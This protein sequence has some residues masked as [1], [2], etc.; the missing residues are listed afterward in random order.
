MR[1]ILVKLQTRWGVDSLW[2]VLVILLVFSI[3]GMSIVYVRAPVYGLLGIDQHSAWWVRVLAFIFIAMPLYQV[4]LLGYGVLLGQRKFF[5][6]FSKR[7]IGRFRRRKRPPSPEASPQ[8]VP[9]AASADES[10]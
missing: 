7:V 4:M 5:W 10:T 6:A 8:A 9:Q 2:Q 1:K 3:T